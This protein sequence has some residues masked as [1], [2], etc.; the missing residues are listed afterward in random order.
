MPVRLGVP[1]QISGLE[2]LVSKPECATG[3]GLL[4]WGS[5][6]ASHL[7]IKKLEYEKRKFLKEL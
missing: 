2:E 7:K 6:N 4:V 3:V 1:N 5:K